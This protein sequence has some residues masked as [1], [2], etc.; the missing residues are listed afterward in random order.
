MEH[1]LINSFGADNDGI[2]MGQN[3]ETVSVHMPPGQYSLSLILVTV[4]C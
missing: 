1:S 4:S 3:S 2:Q